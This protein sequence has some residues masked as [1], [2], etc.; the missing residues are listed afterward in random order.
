MVDFH[1]HR[2]RFLQFSGAA[3]AIPVIAGCDSYEHLQSAQVPRSRFDAD[4]TAQ[5]VTAGIDLSGK[6][7]VVTGC[8]SGIGFETMRVLALRGAHVIGTGRTL[9]KAREAGAKVQ[10]I[11]GAV[12]LELADFDSIVAC[13]DT[14]RSMRLPIDILVCNAGMRAVARELVHGVEKSFAVNH[15]G[16]FILVNRLLDRMYFAEQGR[17]VVVAS[18]AAYTGAPATGIQFNDLSAS[19]NY[20]AS[21]AYGH[22]K[23]AN[24]LFSL[25]LAQLLKGSRITCNALHPGVIGT[26]IARNVNPVLRGGFRLLA[27]ISGKT[28]EE[29]A[30]TSC[31]VATS[32]SL[33]SISGEYFEDCNAVTV[34]GANHMLDAE[35]ASRLWSVSE[36]LTRDYIVEHG[37]PDPSDLIQSYRQAPPAEVL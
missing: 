37:E 19:S 27:S 26:N 24:V 2:R 30:A 28:V 13:A 23:L 35:Q 9:E 15:L 7:A 16:H 3:L 25:H 11:T 12:Q 17:V 5:E 22:S 8:N 18:R 34:A 1:M 32:P 29:G 6:I 31:H 10:G 33:G 4:S 20:S 36:E 14:I 21:R